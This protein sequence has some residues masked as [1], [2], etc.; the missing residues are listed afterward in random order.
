MGMAG[1]SNV[2]K[3]L[4]LTQYGHVI[5]QVEDIDEAITLVHFLSKSDYYVIPDGTWLT[6]TE[7]CRH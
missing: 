5:Y 6:L 2:G 1:G 3:I 7:I 4:L